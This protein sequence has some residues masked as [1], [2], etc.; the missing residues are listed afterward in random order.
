[1]DA[2]GLDM[3]LTFPW[4]PLLCAQALGSYRWP[5]PRVAV[6]GEV[7]AFQ[8]SPGQGEKSVAIHALK[9][10]PDRALYLCY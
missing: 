4:W 9:P 10:V 6:F 2:P 5:V 7:W 1:M 3:G 8:P